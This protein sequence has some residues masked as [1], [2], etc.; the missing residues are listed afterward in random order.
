[1]TAPQLKGASPAD[2]APTEDGATQTL[3]LDISRT[4]ALPIPQVPA[5]S[6]AADVGPKDIG[7]KGI[8]PKSNRAT[9]LM[10]IDL[11]LR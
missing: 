7:P 9:W 11:L 4:F 5:H 2:L 10:L 1:M 6:S 3:T 8:G